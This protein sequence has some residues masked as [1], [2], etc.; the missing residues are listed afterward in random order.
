M[1]PRLMR[2]NIALA[3]GLAWCMLPTPLHAEGPAHQ[4]GVIGLFS[5]DRQQDLRDVLKEIP[6]VALVRLDYA[7]AEVT[8]RYD[9][10]KLFPGSN[11]KKPPTAEQIFQQVNNILAFTSHGAFRLKPHSTMPQDKLTKEVIDI[12]V[13]DCKACR[14]GAYRIVMRID[15]VDRATVTANPS[16]VTAWIDSTKTNRAALE[17]ALKKAEVGVLTKK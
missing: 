15:G 4:Y 12:G 10:A 2:S 7:A 3:L 17:D 9:F 14:F 1:T 13:L 16:Q 8:L 11:P 6:G 5:P